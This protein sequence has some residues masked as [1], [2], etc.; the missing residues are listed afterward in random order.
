[1]RNLDD[2]QEQYSNYPFERF[3]VKYRKSK[4]ISQIKK[5]KHK[6]ILDVGCG[7]D[8]LF[9]DFEDFDEMVVLEPAQKFFDLA[10]G[11]RGK[12]RLESK[13][14][15]LKTTFE[16]YKFKPGD[17][18][19]ILLSSLLHELPEPEAFLKLVSKRIGRKTIVHINTPNARSF[20]RLLAVE[21]GL[22]KNEYEKSK[23]QIRFQRKSVFSSRDIEKLAKDSGLEVV[24][25]GT[26]AFKPFTHEQLLQMLKDSIIN[27]GTI[28]A[29]FRM[30]KFAP[31]LG[32]E[33]FADLKRK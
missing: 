24:E 29:M 11:L 32:S 25:I 20:H 12:L 15:I 27:E 18:D 9:K 26:Y 4:V 6:K 19:I 2:Y 30:D 10:I 31:E 33:I 21:M 3:L 8:P 17:F 13:V 7:L 1:M 22:I 14:K 5:Y 28:E 23:S 16:D